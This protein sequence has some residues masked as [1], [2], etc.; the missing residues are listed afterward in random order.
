MK[1]AWN[2]DFLMTPVELQF[3]IA[4]KRID[5]SRNRRRAS[6]ACVVKVEH[7][8]HGARL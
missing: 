1:L 6:R 5:K 4:Y 3:V 8:L 7:S 2:E